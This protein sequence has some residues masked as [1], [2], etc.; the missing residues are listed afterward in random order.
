M[1]AW[2]SGNMQVSV[3]YVVKDQIIY[4]SVYILVIVFFNNLLF[5]QPG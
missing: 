5:N 4:N 1:A 2:P 3:Q